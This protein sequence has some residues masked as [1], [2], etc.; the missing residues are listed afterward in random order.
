MRKE[1]GLSQTAVAKLGGTDRANISRWENGVYPWG[2]AASRIME[3]LEDVAAGKKPRPLVSGQ[4]EILDLLE[5]LAA[6]V[7]EGLDR[8]DGGI[9]QLT[10]QLSDGAARTGRVRPQGRK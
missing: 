7:V 4:D 6:Q 5:E 3:L 1:L 10:E 9:A 8:I 2:D